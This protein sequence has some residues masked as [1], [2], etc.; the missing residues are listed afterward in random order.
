M[1]GPRISTPDLLSSFYCCLGDH[2]NYPWK[3]LPWKGVSN[4]VLFFD[5]CSGMTMELAKIEEGAT[6]P[7]HYHTTMQTL[8]LYRGRLRTP[9]GEM[10]PGTFNVIPAGQ[11][12][13]PFTAI[14]EAVQFK[15]FSAVPVY[16]LGD[17]STYIYQRD[18][19]VTDAGKLGFAAK[20]R[21]RNFVSP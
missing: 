11:L 19:T 7:E 3:P 10:H 5:P 13:G 21:A 17:G 15:V 20:L 14:E 18:G 1:P 4:K 6:F 8:F 12:H 16:I 2:D 9:D